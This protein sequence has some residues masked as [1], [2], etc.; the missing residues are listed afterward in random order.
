[1]VDEV[2]KWDADDLGAEGEFDGSFQSSGIAVDRVQAT[3]TSCGRGESGNK[4]G[5]DGSWQGA[6]GLSAVEDN[7]LAMACS[8]GLGVN[9]VALSAASS[10]RDAIERDPPPCEAIGGLGGRN[11]GELGQSALVFLGVETTKDDRAI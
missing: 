4:L 2:G 11:D 6:E 7:G 1:M 5:K 3:G 10:D 8:V 9:C